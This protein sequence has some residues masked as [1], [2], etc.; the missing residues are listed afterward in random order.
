MRTIERD[1][2]VRLEVGR[3]DRLLGVN[4]EVEASEIAMQVIS[5]GVL[6]WLALLAVAAASLTLL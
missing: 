6:T 5:F 3:V 4:E 1:R 2:P